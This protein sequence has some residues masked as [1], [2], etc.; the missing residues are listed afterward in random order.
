[1][2]LVALVKPEVKDHAGLSY[3]FPEKQ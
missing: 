2:D 1:L 3:W